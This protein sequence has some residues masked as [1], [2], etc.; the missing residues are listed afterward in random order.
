MNGRP[1]ALIG[2]N[3]DGD[4]ELVKKLNEQNAITWR[5]FFDG[6]TQGPIT[7]AW[8]V[9]AFP[10]MI[11]IDHEGRIAHKDLRGDELDAAIEVLVKAAEAAAEQDG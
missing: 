9:R 4:R 3:T 6:S 2:V 11:V 7:K 5:S 1:F 8:G 10:T